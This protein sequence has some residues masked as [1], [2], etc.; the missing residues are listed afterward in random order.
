MGPLCRQQQQNLGPELGKRPEFHWGLTRSHGEAHFTQWLRSHSE[1]FPLNT[2]K[3]HTNTAIPKPTTSKLRAG[4]MF[5]HP[6][7]T[8]P[9]RKGLWRRTRSPPTPRSTAGPAS[10]TVPSPP[11]RCGCSSVSAAGGS[12]KHAVKLHCTSKGS[13]S[14]TSLQKKFN[15][16]R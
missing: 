1:H 13:V 2:P 16:E 8:R 6:I 15:F 4:R 10:S 3:A 11:E 12:S 9:H 7:L 5:L 14:S